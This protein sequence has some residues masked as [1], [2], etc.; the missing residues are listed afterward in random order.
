MSDTHADYSKFRMNAN[1]S[2]RRT[3]DRIPASRKPL[4]QYDRMQISF[5]IALLYNDHNR[6]AR[7]RMTNKIVLQQSSRIHPFN[8]HIK[9]VV[10]SKVVVH[11]AKLRPEVRSTPFQCLVHYQ[12]PHHHHHHPPLPLHSPTIHPIHQW[13][14][15]S[16]ATSRREKSS[17]LKGSI[18]ALFRKRKENWKYKLHINDSQIP[19]GSVVSSRDS[20]TIRKRHP[21]S[22]YRE[23][24]GEASQMGISQHMARLAPWESKSCRKT[25]KKRKKDEGLLARSSSKSMTC[26][27]S[28]MQTPHTTGYQMCHRSNPSLAPL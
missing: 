3:K 1:E 27:V 21:A 17:N 18:P 16:K 25:K 6:L 9:S 15:L 2:H 26:W 20:S 11:L 7:D 5:L 14:S 12:L 24:G 8:D 22:M 10:P 23:K 4:H 13:K 28:G 19:T